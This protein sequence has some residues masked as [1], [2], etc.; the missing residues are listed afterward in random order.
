MLVRYK[1]WMVTA[2]LS[3]PVAANTATL[4]PVAGPSL[5][6]ILFAANTATISPAVG[7]VLVNKGKG[8]QEV[9][10]NTEVSPGDQVMVRANSRA[11]ITYSS[12]CIVPVT[13]GLRSVVQ[14]EAPCAKESLMT[15]VWQTPGTPSAVAVESGVSL[16]DGGAAAVVPVP[17]P[18]PG[19]LALAGTGLGLAIALSS[20]VRPA[21][22]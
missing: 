19:L 16:K 13:P 5:S 22:P 8:F 1:V 12:D 6:D 2:L 11:M 10:E 20:S 21:S 4:S 17:D 3:A 15:A 9:T 7:A 18:A 14:A